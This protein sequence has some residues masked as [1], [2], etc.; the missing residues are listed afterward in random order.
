MGTNIAAGETRQLIVGGGV[1]KMSAIPKDDIALVDNGS[2]GKVDKDR[3]GCLITEVVTPGFD[4]HDH[5]FLTRQGLEKL[6][7][8]VEGGEES[9]RLFS[10]SVRE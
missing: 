2:N 1:W 6:F 3:V 5:K 7:K 4:W 9:I 8:D 10:G